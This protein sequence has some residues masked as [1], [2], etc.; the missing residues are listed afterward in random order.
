MKYNIKFTDYK[1]KEANL[2]FPI[3][4]FYKKSNIN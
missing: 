2:C 3:N 1:S 4:E